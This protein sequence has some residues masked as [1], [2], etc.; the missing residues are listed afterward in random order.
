MCSD[1]RYVIHYDSSKLLPATV[2]SYDVNTFP[3]SV[4]SQSFSVDPLSLKYVP[5]STSSSLVPVT[6]STPSDVHPMITRSKQHSFRTSFQVLLSYANVPPLSPTSNA[7]SINQAMQYPMWK[8]DMHAELQA[9]SANGTWFVVLLPPG[10]TLIRCK[11]I[12]KVKLCV[13]GSVD[14]HKSRLVAKGFS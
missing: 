10:R 11:L 6:S 3:Q 2:V 13:Y 4:P 8:Y 9:F 14:G 12:F 7:S 5:S 1:V